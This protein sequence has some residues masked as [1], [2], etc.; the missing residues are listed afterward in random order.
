[1]SNS[2]PRIEKLPAWARNLIVKTSRER[3]TAIKTLN[4]FED[5]QKK[6]NIYFE[7]LDFTGQEAGPTNKRCYVQSEKIEIEAFGVHVEV[8]VDQKSNCINIQYDQPDRSLREV[9]LIPES[10]QRFRIVAP[11]NMRF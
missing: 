1:M 9:A 4:F 2:D 5:S 8:S 11:K 10:F 3:D 7:R 6:S